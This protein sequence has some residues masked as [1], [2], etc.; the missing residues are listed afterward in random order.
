VRKGLP[1]KRVLRVLRTRL[2]Y[3]RPFRQSSVRWT[4]LYSRF[5][6]TVRKSLPY[7]SLQDSTRP[8]RI[9][10]TQYV[11][12]LAIPKNYGNVSSTFEGAPRSVPSAVF[13]SRESAIGMAARFPSIPV[14]SCHSGRFILRPSSAWPQNVFAN[15]QIFLCV[16]GNITCG[17]VLR[18]CL[19]LASL[20]AV[21]RRLGI[22]HKAVR[23]C[24]EAVTRRL[25]SGQDALLKRSLGGSRGRQTA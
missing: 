3:R 25:R 7:R 13:S 1:N 9:L 11:A 6:R 16:R 17:C 10:S 12:F 21:M 5:C 19:R 23:S 15:I 22:D 4:L 18:L 8:Y 14:L 20:E 2:Q 24:L